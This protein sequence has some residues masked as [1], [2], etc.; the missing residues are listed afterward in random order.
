MENG[1]ALS[2]YKTDWK[3]NR[4]MKP[5]RVRQD[6][7]TIE[8]KREILEKYKSLPS[9]KKGEFLTS[10]GLCYQHIN[11]YKK[12]VSIH[13]REQAREEAK[14]LFTEHNERVNSIV[15]E[16]PHTSELGYVVNGPIRWE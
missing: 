12:Q 13:T 10:L 7:C 3:E 4:D 5:G 8:R 16:L 2:K 11:S 15:V 14:R 1:K 6:S 9:G